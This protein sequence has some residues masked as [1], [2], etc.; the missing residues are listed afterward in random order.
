MDEK[1]E[2]YQKKTIEA[3]LNTITTK[4]EELTVDK[5]IKRRRWIWELIQNANDCA[6]EDGV[7][8][9]IK[10]NKDEL[11][12]SHNGNI[13]TYNNLLDL[14]T[15]ISSKRTD[16]DEKVGK[17][18]TGFIATHLISEIVTVKGVYH[19]KKDSMNYKCLSLKID[20]SGKT[21]EEIKNSIMK[22]INDLDLLDSGQNIEWN[23]DKN[24]PTTSFVYD[25]TNN[26]S[27]D[28]ETAIKSGENDLD[29]A[30]AFV[31]AFS[32]RIKKVIFNQ[33]AY[34]STCNQITINEN[35]RVIEV[36]MTYGDPLKRPTYKKILVCSDPIKDV[37]IAVLVEPCGNNNAFRCCSTKDMTKLFCTFP[38]IG[39]EDFCFPILLN[40]PNFKVLQ[41][42]NDIN[43]ENS[44]NKEILETAKYLYKKV[45][46]YA[47]ENNW[48]DLYNLCYMSKSK[49]TQFQR[50]TFDSIQAIYRVLPIV[51]VQKYIDSNNKKSLYSTENGKLTH[52]VIIPFMDNPEYSDELWDLISQIK[53]KPIPT[54]ISNKHWSAISPGNKVTL[55]KVYNIL[56]KDKMISDFCTWFDRVDDAIPWLNNFY[57]LWI[58][59]SDNQEFLSKGIAPNQ[60]DQFVEVSKLNF[61]NN[62]DEELKDILTFFEP[63]FKT[64]LL[65][66]GLTALA[67][68]RINSYDNEAVSSKIN[69]YIRKQFS[70]ESNNTVKRSTSIQDIFNRISDWFLKKP[71]IAKPLF[72]DIF[73]KKHQLS[74]H[75]ET[76]RR[77]ELAANVESTM[78]ENNLEL[79]QLDIFIKESSRLL[80][81][82]EKGDIMFSEDAK[83]LFQHI[84][85]K[86]IYSKERL[87]YLMKRSIE[88]IYNSLSKNPL[89]TIE[90]TLSEWQQNKYSTTVFSAIRDKTNIRIVIRPSDDDKIIFY[91]DAEL[92]A[93]DDTAY[94]LWTDD[95]KGTVRMITLGDL[96]KTTGMSSI[97]LKKVF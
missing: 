4:L 48:S 21:D 46:R 44:N 37:S 50:Q 28:I 38:L 20:R 70:N 90:S 71:D 7:T 22:S 66:K 33:T 25:L 27:T 6:T 68:I 67:D 14:I 12:F 45:V 57:N 40:S 43:E 62:I 95:G 39:T 60:M 34:Y 61:D 64:K 93:L 59:S 87:E 10:T 42:R 74:S 51:D 1:T 30:I 96:I 35:M 49:D 72:K 82:Y 9:W 56:L 18:G 94:E 88:N 86:S 32:D 17:F 55:Q 23:Y 83:K 2:V 53:T 85:S 76:I 29:K 31:L 79:A 89:Y 3:A 73:D 36:E 11:V 97:P 92:E 16:D 78:K 47:S 15:Q 65:Y 84:S 5:E 69:D 41:E 54:K 81:L 13:F 77:L 52:A 8:I 58:R 24:V 63:N 91:E 75:E 26:R 80:Q 19:N